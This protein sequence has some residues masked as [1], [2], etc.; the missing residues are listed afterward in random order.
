MLQIIIIAVIIA[1]DQLSKI[2]L[3]PEIQNESV[4]VISNIF[5]LT[6]VNNRGASFGMMQGAQ[7]FFIIVTS[8]VLVAAAVFMVKTRKRQE[9]FLKISLSLIFGGAFG[10][11]ID[12]IIFGYVRDFLDFSRIGFP[13]VFNMADACLVVGSILLGVYVI[14]FYK[15]Q[16]GKGLFARLGKKESKAESDE[17]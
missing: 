13:W 1:A 7:I 8:I 3:M 2:F 14:F 6:H 11:F 15:E 16:D 5:Y 10:N 9:L 12:R 4:T 17:K